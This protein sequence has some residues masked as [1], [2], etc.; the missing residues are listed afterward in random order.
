MLKNDMKYETNVK[1][2]EKL[3]FCS[4]IKYSQISAYI[5][6]LEFYEKIVSFFV[7]LPRH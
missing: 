6:V 2:L 7:F 1:T 3:I 5:V 4:T